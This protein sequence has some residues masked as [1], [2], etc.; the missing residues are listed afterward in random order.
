LTQTGFT[1][2]S[3]S[4][5]SGGSALTLFEQAAAKVA[6]RPPIA[7]PLSPDELRAEAA[8]VR[9]EVAEATALAE[10]GWALR[11]A[12]Y[13]A[14]TLRR[15]LNRSI[16]AEQRRLETDKRRQEGG[17]Y[18]GQH[19]TDGR[20][21]RLAVDLEAWDFLKAASIRRRIP[22]GYL[23]ANLVT[24]AVSH[25][26]LPRVVRD[27]RCATQRFVRLILLDVE[28]WTTFKAMAVDAHVTSTRML[29]LIA[30]REAR[31]LG[32]RAEVSD[33]PAV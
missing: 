3:D 28:T 9:R 26:A 12:E 6:Q 22:V 25:S 18:A 8:R 33:E 5:G 7:D 17:L 30:E 27:D 13:A 2:D 31:R 10:A 29:G 23:L 21:T 24:E 4:G 32:W 16:S 14:T 20:P 15:R 19:R 1:I 11:D